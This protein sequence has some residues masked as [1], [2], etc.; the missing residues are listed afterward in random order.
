MTDPTAAHPSADP[1][2]IAGRRRLF[3][4]AVA[5]TIALMLLAMIAA[6]GPGGID[7]L[8]V[9]M[10]VLLAATLPWSAI[11]FW[12]AAIGFWLMR[13]LPDPTGYICPPAARVTGFEPIVARTA[14]VMCIRNEAPER[15]FGNLRRLMDALAARGEAAWFPVHILSDTDDDGFARAEAAATDELRARHAGAFAVHYRRRAVNTG[16]KAGNLRDF[17]KTSGHTAEFMITLDADSLM[18]ADRVLRLVRIMQ[19]APELGILQ[20]I[21]TGLPS[22]S[23]FARIFQFGMRL[24]MRSYTLGSAWWQADCGPY[25]GHNA[26]IRIAPFRDHCHLPTLPGKPPLGGEILSHDQVE[27]VFM[28]RAGFD[29]RVLPEEEGSFEEN[30]TT[31]IEFVRRDLRWCQGNMQ[32]L[33]LLRLPGI[34]PVSRVQLVLAVLMFIG[35]PAWVALVGLVIARLAIS[36]ADWLA[37]GPAS[38]VWAMVI[39]MTYAPR[40]ATLIDVLLHAPARRR[41]GGGLRVLASAVVETVFSLGLWSIMALAHSRLMLAFAFGRSV[42][43]DGQSRDAV[44]VP[45]HL[46]WHNL[47][48]HTLIGLVALFGLAFAPPAAFW[49]GFAVTFGCLLAVPFAIVTATPV[50]GR[51]MARHRLA[52]IPEEIDTPP[53]VAA[54]DLPALRR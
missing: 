33:N 5:L 17:L 28:R 14:L 45:W 42:G 49:M 7:A 37:A 6:V 9:T 25:W 29:V 35:L 30:P 4:S 48:V 54:L 8:D 50:L 31:L 13:R 19:A 10:I 21:I 23:A 44:G 16:F 1:A 32:Y 47:R 51:L 20:N 15:V 39:L 34:L 36:G 22:A 24:G 3:A 43:W 38:F 11:G 12:N 27:A 52:A 18:S 40:W 2:R 41:F 46:A 26:I 53:E